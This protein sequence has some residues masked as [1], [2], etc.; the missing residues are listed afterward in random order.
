MI[1]ETQE[2]GTKRRV[3][4]DTSERG[5]HSFK[6]YFKRATS[7][8]LVLL[9]LKEEAMYVY[10]LASELGKRSK[11]SYTMSFLYPVL[12]RLE[13]L[14]YVAESHKEISE[15]N[16]VRNY[17]EIT[18]AG[19]EYLEKIL[20]EYDDLLEAVQQIRNYKKES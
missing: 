12:Y 7:Q 18:E 20:S 3:K 16:R 14:G 13:S 10:Q 1:S 8:M 17:Y 11:N 9:L 19:R 15:G 2:S 5:G 6:D 4:R